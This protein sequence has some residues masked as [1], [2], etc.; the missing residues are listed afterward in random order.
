M[1]TSP[2]AI[3]T[4]EAGGIRGVSITSLDQRE[5]FEG[6]KRALYPIEGSERVLEVDTVFSL[7]RKPH[8][9][10]FLAESGIEFD[11]AGG[12]AID[13]E[14]SMTTRPGVFAIGSEADAAVIRAI[15]AGQKAAFD[16]ERSLTGFS[17][18]ERE[19]ELLEQRTIDAPDDLESRIRVEEIS[20]HHTKYRSGKNRVKDFDIYRP[21][22]SRKAAAA[23]AKR[24]L[25]CDLESIAGRKRMA[26]EKPV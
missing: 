24:C 2:I 20:R 3:E 26:G 14:T 11:E 9:L 19:I 7:F 22:L 1:L 8:D 18:R 10:G 4:D 17:V 5:W 12:V 23:E 15:R 16:V 25:R 21:C 13:P 6:G